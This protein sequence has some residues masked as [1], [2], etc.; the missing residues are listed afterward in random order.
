MKTVRIMTKTLRHYLRTIGLLVAFVCDAAP[1]TWSPFTTNQ[2]PRQVKWSE[3]TAQQPAEFAGTEVRNKAGWKFALKA[4][5]TNLPTAAVAKQG[6]KWKLSVSWENRIHQ[7]EVPDASDYEEVLLSS[8]DLNGDKIPDFIL[9]YDP[10]GCGLAAIG[11]T[12]TLVLSGKN[13]QRSHELYQ[14]GFGPDSLVQFKR[15]GP[16]H[17]VVTDMLQLGAG[18]SRDRREHSYWVYR[19]FR[20]EGDSLKAEPVG[21]EGFPRWIQYLRRSNHAETTLLTK[22]QKRKLEAGLDSPKVLGSSK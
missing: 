16:W 8:A 4:A 19:L 9:R 5:G 20:I 18:V 21:V 22:Q 3:W 10:H 11:Q 12:V 1:E 2:A 14:F 15:D 13:G 6:Q 17:W 7:A